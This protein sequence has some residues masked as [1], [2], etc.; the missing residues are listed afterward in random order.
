MQKACHFY[1]P[2]RRPKRWRRKQAPLVKSVWVEPGIHIQVGISLY[3]F[4]VL[5]SDLDG[6][7]VFSVSS[8]NNQPTA[9]TT[10]DCFEMSSIATLA[11]MDHYGLQLVPVVQRMRKSLRAPATD[12]LLQAYRLVV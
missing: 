4:R 5:W 10:G 8:W 7:F 3:E 12:Q 11:Q 9:V 2:A 1:Q 6:S